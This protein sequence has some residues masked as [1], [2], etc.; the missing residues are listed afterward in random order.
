MIDNMNIHLL[1]WMLR[2]LVK[3]ANLWVE[4]LLCSRV[5]VLTALGS[6]TFT[7]IA[8]LLALLH[9]RTGQRSAKTPQLRHTR[10]RWDKLQLCSCCAAYWSTC[11]CTCAGCASGP[12]C[13]GS[14]GRRNPGGKGE[15][16]SYRVL[17]CSESERSCY[18]K[19][20]TQEGVMRQAGSSTD[21]KIK[22]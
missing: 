20:G 22:L 13:C 11:I 15:V 2:C 5:A 9:S 21:S 12:C 6:L 17:S 16:V 3:G 1:R 18:L 4:L 7:G 10:P 8:P 19:R 14:T